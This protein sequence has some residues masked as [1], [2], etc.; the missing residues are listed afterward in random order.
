MAPARKRG[1]RNVTVLWDVPPNSL[2]SITVIME[3]HAVS[4]FK[5]KRS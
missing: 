4:V 5:E 2:V 3:E 1:K